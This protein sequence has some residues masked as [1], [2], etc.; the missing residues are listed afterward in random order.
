MN[1]YWKQSKRDFTESLSSFEVK[2]LADP[3]TVGR[4]T[5]TDKFVEKVD[6]DVQLTDDTVLVT[7]TFNTE[8]EAVAYVL[9][10]GGAIKLIE[11]EYLIGKIVQQAKYV[12]EMYD[13]D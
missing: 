4:M 2:V 9:G 1:E 11:P 8:Q 10:F 6:A 5:F 13:A 12:I 7:L 3:T